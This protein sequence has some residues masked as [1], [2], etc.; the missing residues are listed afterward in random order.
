MR[1]RGCW[2]GQDPRR[3][4]AQMSKGL[5]PVGCLVAAIAD[6]TF[7]VADRHAAREKPV[8]VPDAGCCRHFRLGC[9]SWSRWLIHCSNSSQSMGGT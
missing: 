8:G 3:P 7:V 9:T 6:P 1:P 2:I 5:S 4:P